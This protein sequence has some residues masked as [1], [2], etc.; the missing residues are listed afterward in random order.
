M[1]NKEER[2]GS[3]WTAFRF[4]LDGV[5][6]SVLVVNVLKID[7]TDFLVC[8]QIASLSQRLFGHGLLAWH[9][10]QTFCPPDPVVGAWVHDGVWVVVSV[11]D[12]VLTPWHPTAEANLQF[13]CLVCVWIFSCLADTKTHFAIQDLWVVDVDI[14]IG[15]QRVFCACAFSL[16]KAVREFLNW[17]PS[18]NVAQDVKVI[19]C[20]HLWTRFEV[21]C[22][23]FLRLSR[24]G[25]DANENGHPN[26]SHDFFKRIFAAVQNWK[27]SPVTFFVFLKL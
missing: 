7:N 27:I 25:D 1:K 15:F 12:Q 21:C 22:H 2:K 13:W 14:S 11:E 10:P 3:C 26:P 16:T 24:S 19:F 5:A 17:V 8:E 9:D 20:R 23:L 6:D 18:P 4:S